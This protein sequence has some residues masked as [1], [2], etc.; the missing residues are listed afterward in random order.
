MITT[1]PKTLDKFSASPVGD[2]EEFFRIMGEKKFA[3]PGVDLTYVGY[4]DGNHFFQEWGNKE[5]FVVS[6]NGWTPKN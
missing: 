3:F 5:P 1:F 6:A 2:R 4:A